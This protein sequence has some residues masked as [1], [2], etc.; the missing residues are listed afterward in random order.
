MMQS[1]PYY[2]NI[3]HKIAKFILIFGLAVFY[4][5][6]HMH[7]L[8]SW[9]FGLFP[10]IICSNTFKYKGSWMKMFSVTL[11]IFL[12]IT[13]CF[14]EQFGWVIHADAFSWCWKGQ[15]RFSIKY[16][17]IEALFSLKH[18][19]VVHQGFIRF[20]GVKIMYY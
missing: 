2:S 13:F 1:K 3:W 14:S 16:F 5:N 15:W 17:Y 6:T 7:Y 18:S 20:R 9:V 12:N 4:L 10:A 19:F 8:F 11:H